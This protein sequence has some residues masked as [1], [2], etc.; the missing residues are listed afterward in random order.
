M[1]EY[2]TEAAE[3]VIGVQEQET[4]DDSHIFFL[5]RLWSQSIN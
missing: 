3:E 1:P 2:K 4:P 5:L